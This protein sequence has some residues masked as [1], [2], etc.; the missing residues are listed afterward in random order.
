MLLRSEV[1]KGGLEQLYEIL[2]ESSAEQI[3]V[4]MRLVLRASEAG[5]PVLFFCKVLL[6]WYYL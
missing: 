3:L 1:N 2:L 5:R 6:P 4:V